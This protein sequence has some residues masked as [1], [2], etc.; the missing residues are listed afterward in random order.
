MFNM[1]KYDVVL[2]LDYSIPRKSRVGRLAFINI[3]NIKRSGLQGER[4]ASN[5]VGYE[6]H[7]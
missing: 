7:G 3:D 5:Y 4:I 6:D 1:D 2:S